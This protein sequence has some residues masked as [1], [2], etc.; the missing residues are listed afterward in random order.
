MLNHLVEFAECQVR[1]GHFEAPGW[2]LA[3]SEDLEEAR[4][5]AKVQGRPYHPHSYTFWLR[6]ELPIDSLELYQIAERSSEAALP[7]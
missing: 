5:L 2:L 3:E 1:G 7:E 6:S 4:R